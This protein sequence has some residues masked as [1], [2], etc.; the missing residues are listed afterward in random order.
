MAAERSQ[1]NRVDERFQQLRKLGQPAFM[2]FITAGDPDLE[3][4]GNIL[5]AAEKAGSD[6]IELGFPFSDPVADGPVIQVSY[7]RV[8][9]RGQRTEDVFR[10]VEKA[11]EESDI[12]IVA[13]ISY[14][15]VY[16][17]GFDRFVDRA[18]RA[19]I[20]GATIPDLPVEEAE[21]FHQ[22]ALA[23]DFRLI[24]FVTPTTTPARRAMVVRVARGFIYYISVR[25]IT[26]ER[27]SLPADLRENIRG[28]RSET[29]VPVAV[30]FGV[31]TPAQARLVGELADG[32]IVGSAI[33]TRIHEAS[34]RGEDPAAAAADFIGTMS[35]AA[36]GLS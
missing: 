11:R 1:M 18:L 2:P 16:K 23:N 7:T 10:M 8:F 28:L 15:L 29:D 34:Q 31:S 19:G 24:C 21:Q 13:M 32:V 17:M 20:D 35:Q 9:E 22:Q 27:D 4:T 30:G 36:K 25:G 6:V 26:G 14:S 12:P 33:V 5:L 3:T